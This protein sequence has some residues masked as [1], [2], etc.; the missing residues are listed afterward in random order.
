MAL[1]KPPAMRVAVYHRV[2]T[3]DQNPTLA[4][5][6]LQ[7]AAARLGGKVVLDIEETGSGAATT[8]LAFSA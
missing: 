4:R 2:S 5:E 8:T 6:E 7:A 3:L 1:M